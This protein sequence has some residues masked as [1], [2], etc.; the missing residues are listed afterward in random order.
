MTRPCFTVNSHQQIELAQI[1]GGAPDNL[2]A[3]VAFATS[4]VAQMRSYLLAHGVA[5]KPIVKDANGLEHFE[6]LDPEGHPISFVQ[7]SDHF[8]SATGD[9]I[10]NRIFHAGFIVKDNAAEDR[11]YRDLLGFRMY[12]HGGFKDNDM[13]WEELQVPDGSDWIEYM[14]NI[15]PRADKQERGIQNHFSLGVPN[16]KST[17]ERLKVHGLTATANGRST[18]T[19]PTPP[20]SSSWNTSPRSLRVAIPTNRSIRDRDRLPYQTFCKEVNMRRAL[21]FLII[22][23]TLLPAVTYAPPPRPLISGLNFVRFQVSNIEAATHF[24]HDLLGLPVMGPGI[25]SGEV[26]D[27]AF[28]LNPIQRIVIAKERVSRR[29]DLIDAISVQTADAKKLREYLRARGLRPG[30]LVYD[31]DAEVHFEVSDP[32]QH[33]IL[34]TSWQGGILGDV[35]GG[36]NSASTR[37]IHV[38][39]VVRDRVAMEHFYKDILGFKPYWHGG[40]KDGKDDWVGLQVPDGTDWVEFMLNVSPDADKHTLGVMNH[41]ALGVP[42]IHAAQKQLL[43]NGMKLTEEP[44]IGRDGKWQLNVYDPD[45]TRVEFMEFTPV[46]KPCCSEFTGPHPKP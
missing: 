37:L 14:L 13:D 15:P 18:S 31:S 10:S 32:G 4:D 33:R 21:F 46:Q 41:I 23:A 34:F 29:T 43:T 45:D 27:L 26:R 24:Y 2:L 1:S 38:G 19:T 3:T 40:M 30:P 7:Q 39:F 8:F 11:F 16:I 42:D 22:A 25:G 9:Q 44:K 17:F 20:A 35:M 36:H 28:F 5:A 12:W 6:L